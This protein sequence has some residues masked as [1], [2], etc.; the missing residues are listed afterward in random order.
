MADKIDILLGLITC[1]RP[2]YLIE[3]LDSLARQSIFNTEVN[4]STLIVDNDQ[5]QSARHIY[6]S[7]SNTFPGKLEYYHETKQGI[8]Y[9]RNRVLSHAAQQESDYIVFIDDDETASVTWLETLHTL[10]KENDVDAIQGLVVS[11]LPDGNLPGWANKAKRKEGNKKEGCSR[12][13]LST[14]NVIFS[15]RL[16]RDLGL[17]FD[18]SFALTGGSDMDFF[19]RA[20]KL[21]STHI[22]TNKAIVY[23]KIPQSRLNLSWQFQRLFR[24]GATNTYM[25]LQQKGFLPTLLRYVPKIAARILLGPIILLLLGI[26][27]S[28]MRLLAIQWIGS[29]IGHTTGFL[30]IMGQ[31]YSK[32]HG[33]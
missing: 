18:E 22:W 1:K 8:P 19:E 25:S 11:I 10:I 13:G 30:G 21:G 9:A 28:N 17:R 7:Y 33:N 15:S 27:S 32:I 23:E 14:N 4:V 29:A 12:I 5:Q 24:V 16:I 20:A 6:Q 2:N 3:L 31:E 26:F